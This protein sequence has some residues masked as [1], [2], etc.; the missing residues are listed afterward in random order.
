MGHRQ[1]SGLA[2]APRTRGGLVSLG[3]PTIIPAFVAQ[4]LV[5]TLASG[6]R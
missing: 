1:R 3:V 4:A 5:A 6:P 2:D